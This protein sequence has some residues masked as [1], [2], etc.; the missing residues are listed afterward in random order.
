[1]LSTETDLSTCTMIICDAPSTSHPTPHTSIPHPHPT[2]PWNK[3]DSY[4][5][6]NHT[7]IDVNQFYSWLFSIKYLGEIFLNVQNKHCGDPTL[8]KSITG[9]SESEEMCFIYTR[10][11]S[12]YWCVCVVPLTTLLD[13][14]T[15]PAWP[16]YDCQWCSGITS[17][18]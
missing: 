18:G 15:L 5:V 2:Q 14:H 10:R 7:T 12:K 17:M 4:L 6:L 3:N 16:L 11:G 13:C 8:H 9:S 1:M